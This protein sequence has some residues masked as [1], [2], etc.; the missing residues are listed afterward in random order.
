MNE[1]QE[2]QWNALIRRISRLIK[3]RYR[4]VA[5]EGYLVPNTLAWGDWDDPD[6]VRHHG[7]HV[8]TIRRPRK[9]AR[10]ML[11]AV[12]CY[13]YARDDDADFGGLLEMSAA[14][15]YAMAIAIGFR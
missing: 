2:A 6:A 15:I 3:D 10:E 12:W 13:M 14:D 11:R 1:E 7:A 9:I 8:G 4:S 5:G